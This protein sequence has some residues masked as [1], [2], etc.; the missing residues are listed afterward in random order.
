[1]N[2]FIILLAVLG[3]WLLGV[4]CGWYWARSEGY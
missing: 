4:F 1:M 2:D 3:V